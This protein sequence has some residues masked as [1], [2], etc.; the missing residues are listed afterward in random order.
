MCVGGTRHGRAVGYEGE[1]VAHVV[2]GLAMPERPWP[3]HGKISSR[4]GLVRPRDRQHTRHESA[5]ETAG[6]ID[7]MTLIEHEIA[8]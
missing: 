7:G 6:G 5:Y 4:H 3:E 1:M 8:K 2:D